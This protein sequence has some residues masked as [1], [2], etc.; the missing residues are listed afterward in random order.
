[1]QI[2]H[3]HIIRGSRIPPQFVG[4]QR[5]TTNVGAQQIIDYQIPED[6]DLWLMTGVCIGEPT[7]AENVTHL[8]LVVLPGGIDAPDN[9][10]VLAHGPGG[11]AAVREVLNLS[12]DVYLP[13]RSIV[14]LFA[15]YSAGVLAK[16][17]EFQITGWLVPPFDLPL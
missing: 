4:F 16:S 5:I 1:M 12:H 7:G 11:A 2:T 17:T 8:H 3:G 14:R 13:R 6:R 10:I 15:Q 9:R